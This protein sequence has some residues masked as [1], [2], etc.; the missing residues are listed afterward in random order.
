MGRRHLA[1]AL[2]GTAVALAASLPA[3]ASAAPLRGIS[4]SMVCIAPS[5]AAGIDAMLTRAGSPLAGEG[6]TFVRASQEV[7]LDPRAL[8][9][10]AA[11]ETMLETYLPSQVIKNPFG[12]GP[13]WSFATERAAI[14]RAASTLG[15]GYL[16]EGR[17]TLASIGSKWAPLGAANDPGGL[18]ANWTA[19]VG[20]YYAAL[21]GDPSREVLASAQDPAPGC[22]GGTATAVPEADRPDAPAASAQ[23]VV[24]AWGGQAA[25]GAATVDGF[26]FPLALPVGAPAVYGDSF[27]E[28]GA[29]ECGQDSRRQCAVTIASTPGAHAVA[30]AAGTLRSVDAA[31]Q[32]EGLAFWIETPSGDRIGYG[33]LSSYAPGVVDGATVAAGQPLGTDSGTLRIAL[34]KGGARVDPYPLLEATR[35]ATR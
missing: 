21:G 23:P 20:T 24:T 31:A 13:G 25:E 7:G 8:V 2:A 1:A 27:L 28:P 19:G 22:A 12:L 5:D 30:A 34:V 35:P 9:A 26:V 4:A 33:P 10:I 32:E 14:E 6:A 29:V 11:H 18:N 3:A 17:T 16:G 15:S